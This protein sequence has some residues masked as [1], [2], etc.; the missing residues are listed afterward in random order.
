MILSYAYIVSYA[1]QLREQQQQSPIS[2]YHENIFRI[3]Y[4]FCLFI[5]LFMQSILQKSISKGDFHVVV[6][7]VVFFASLSIFGFQIIKKFAHIVQTL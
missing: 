6:V 5:S 2:L 7:V 4:N 1:I 3:F